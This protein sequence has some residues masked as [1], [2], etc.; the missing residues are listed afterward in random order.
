[1]GYRSG[2]YIKKRGRDHFADQGFQGKVEYRSNWSV[3]PFIHQK[4]WQR[5][6]FCWYSRVQINLICTN[7]DLHLICTFIFLQKPG[8]DQI[9]ITKQKQSRDQE[10]KRKSRYRSYYKLSPCKLIC[11]LCLLMKLWSVHSILYN[12]PDQKWVRDQGWVRKSREHTR[13]LKYTSK[14]RYISIISR[15]DGVEIKLKPIKPDLAGERKAQ[16]EIWWHNVAICCYQWK[17]LWS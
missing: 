4:L 3:P 1:M 10:T 6:N 16:W 15:W 2:S 11:T 7:A 14:Q 9:S 5:S 13:A 17:L 8:I 12:V